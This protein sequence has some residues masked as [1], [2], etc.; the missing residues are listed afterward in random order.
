AIPVYYFV[1]DVLYADG[2][3]LC[4]AKLAD[5]KAV[6][7]KV[8]T[9]SHN[10]NILSFF[11]DD[12]MAA[13]QACVENGFEG[14][15][16]KRLDSI[17]EPG[18]RSPDWIKVKAQQTDEFVVGGF[19][20]GQGSRASAFGALLLGSYDQSGHF[21]YCGSVGTGFDERLLRETM[22]RVEPLKQAKHP[23]LKRPDEKKIV[24]WLKPQVVVEVKFMDWTR[25]FHLRTP[26]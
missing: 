4:G 3:D 20:Q 7:A 24:T 19:T 14:I 5:R 25:D 21:I 13:Y 22:R 11:K 26:V 17:Y 8:L 15:V 16:A 6:L 12:G 23:F 18:R 1:F 10:V 2:F 9:S